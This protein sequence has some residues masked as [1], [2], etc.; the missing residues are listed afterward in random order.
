MNRQK[1]RLALSVT[2]VLLALAGALVVRALIPRATPDWV[3]AGSVF[4]ATTCSPAPAP[5]FT[6]KD[7]D[8]VQAQLAPNP[9]EVLLVTFWS[10]WCI[11]CREELPGLLA[12]GRDLQAQHPGRIR[13]IGVS[14]DE[15]AKRVH[16]YVEELRRHNGAPPWTV[17]LDTSDQVALAAYYTTAKTTTIPDEYVLPQTYVVDRAAHLVGYIE[18]SRDWTSSAA[19]DY[20]EA[21]LRDEPAAQTQRESPL[22]PLAHLLRLSTDSLRHRSD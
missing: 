22:G 11:S 19:R 1:K 14:M 16:R 17:L 10:A 21:L 13:I 3:V 7:L 5:H 8:G 20:V 15:D 2:L 12:L 6:L 9:G 4:G 18:G